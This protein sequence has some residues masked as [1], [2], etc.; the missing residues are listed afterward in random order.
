MNVTL[1]KGGKIPLPKEFLEKLNLKD[2]DEVTVETWI[3]S[4]GNPYVFVF[5]P[6]HETTRIL[7]NKLF[8]RKLRAP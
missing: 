6:M 2:G 3:L 8:G 1:E 7:L 5:S 4:D